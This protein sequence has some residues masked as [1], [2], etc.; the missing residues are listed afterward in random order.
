MTAKQNS[1]QITGLILA[2]GRSSR[3]DGNDKGL[4]K[5][6]NSTMIEHV[7]KRLET[8]VST[9]LIS[10]NR[11]LERY[12]Q[13]N[14]PV[15]VDDYDDYRGPLAGMARGL[16]H[17][18]SDYLLTVPCDGPLLPL[19][20]AQRMSQFA[21]QQQAPAVLAFDGQYRQPTYNLIHKDL[22]AALSL[23]LENNEHKLGKW[24]MDN[25]AITVD[26]SDQAAAFLNVNTPDDLE[27]LSQQ[28]LLDSIS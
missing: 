4:L 1:Q 13:F 20:L 21:Y 19:D 5:L 11:H 6:G 23:S 22:L 9:L 2:G 15:L 10:A 12:Q 7:L 26:F 28:L 24:L 17:S 14:Y 8:Q 3:M 16:A 25:G 27:L 18:K